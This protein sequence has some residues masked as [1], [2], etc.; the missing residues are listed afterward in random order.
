MDTLRSSGIHEVYK[1]DGLVNSTICFFILSRKN[2]ILAFACVLTL[3]KQSLVV[4]FESNSTE[5][6]VLI[7]GDVHEWFRM[8]DT[9]RFESSTAISKC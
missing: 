6:D 9:E 4:I 8:Q 1:L 7:S 3:E 2:Y 5:L